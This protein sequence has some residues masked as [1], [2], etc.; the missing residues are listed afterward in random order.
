MP[1]S[2]PNRKTSIEDL[3]GSI[4]SV[5]PPGLSADVRRNLD[6]SV[7][8][9]LENLEIVTRAELEVQET[10]LR[11]ARQKLDELEMRV[12]QLE[13]AKQAASDSESAS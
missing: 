11:R 3:L 4:S 1:A 9:V 13:Q 6:A 7:R 2:N 5:L 8:A 10:A 12:K